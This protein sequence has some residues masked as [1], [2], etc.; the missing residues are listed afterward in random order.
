MHIDP[1][2]GKDDTKDD[3]TVELFVKQTKDAVEAFSEQVMST[4]AAFENKTDVE[5]GIIYKRGD[6]GKLKVTMDKEAEARKLLHEKY[7]T[8][9]THNERK[10]AEAAWEDFHYYQNVWNR[11]YFDPAQK[12]YETKKERAYMESIEEVSQDP[13]NLMITHD[14]ED[15]SALYE[16]AKRRDAVK[17][18]DGPGDYKRLYDQWLNR[19]ISL[20]MRFKLAYRKR[21]PDVVRPRDAHRYSQPP[22]GTTNRTLESYRARHEH[23]ETQFPRRKRKRIDDTEVEELYNKKEEVEKDKELERIGQMEPI[24]WR[25]DDEEV[26]KWQYEIET[27]EKYPIAENAQDTKDLIPAEH[28]PHHASTETSFDWPTS[29]DADWGNRITLTLNKKEYLYERDSDIEDMKEDDLRKRRDSS[30][31][32]RKVDERPRYKKV[33]DG[34]PRETEELELA[35][36]PDDT[37]KGRDLNGDWIR[38]VKKVVDQ[39]MKYELGP[40]KQRVVE[41]PRFLFRRRFQVRLKAIPVLNGTRPQDHVR[42]NRTDE[43]SDD[44]EEDCTKNNM[45]YPWS[46]NANPHQVADWSGNQEGGE[47]PAKSDPNGDDEESDDDG[48]LFRQSYEECSECPTRRRA[49]QMLAALQEELGVYPFLTAEEMIPWLKGGMDYDEIKAEY[50]AWI[51]ASKDAA[52]GGTV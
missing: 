34:P 32:V 42:E 3:K 47:A 11:R 51:E 50:A 23:L 31:R 19:V 41:D 38:G 45:N 4:W 52:E 33:P 37:V 44:E 49:R 39:P 12:F 48:D 8:W 2:S 43:L 30:G 16:P 40:R 26:K 15:F 28:V 17:S 21:M 5:T 18:G 36:N 27:G 46:G 22:R 13:S 6:S 7:Q 24:Q 10:F 29:F 35:R 25:L 1:K 9:H 14:P 20:Y